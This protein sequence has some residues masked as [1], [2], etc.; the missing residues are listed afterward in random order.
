MMKHVGWGGCATNSGG[1][2]KPLDMENAGMPADDVFQVDA[3]TWIL[4]LVKGGVVMPFNPR[5]VLIYSRIMPAVLAD[6]DDVP[7]KC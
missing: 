4:P 7:T 5:L 2:M 1:A 6:I 3:S